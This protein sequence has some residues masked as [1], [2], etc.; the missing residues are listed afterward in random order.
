[1]QQLTQF[2][3]WC[4]KKACVKLV[5]NSDNYCALRAILIAK[6]YVDKD[7]EAYKLT[8][9]NSEE[10]NVR[11]LKFAQEIHLPNKKCGIEEIFKIESHLKDYQ[12]TVL[13]CEGKIHNIPLYIGEIK[14]KFI[15]ITY[16]GNHFAAITKMTGFF[17]RDYSCHYCKI[18]FNNEIHKCE[19]NCLQN[20]LR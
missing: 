12:I 8:F 6:A 18:S 4:L 19:Y 14:E 1:M 2:E 16:T 9:P 5:F 20:S 15:Y 7:P 10:L 13:N 17:G 3:K 11:V